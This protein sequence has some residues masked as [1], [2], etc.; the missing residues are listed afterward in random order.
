MIYRLYLLINVP[1]L[2]S[3]IHGRWL[4]REPGGSLYEVEITIKTQLNMLRI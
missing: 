3:N 1:F 2:D 4:D